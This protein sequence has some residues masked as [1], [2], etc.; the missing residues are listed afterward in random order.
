MPVNI[1]SEQLASPS[2]TPTVS[3]PNAVNKNLQESSFTDSAR[4]SPLSDSVAVT[5]K[6]TDFHAD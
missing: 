6:N 3:T 5:P 1:S 4:F 2:S